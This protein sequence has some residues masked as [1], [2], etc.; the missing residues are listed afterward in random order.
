M[1]T[2]FPTTRWSCV[3]ALHD[4]DDVVRWR[5]LNELLEMYRPALLHYA[6]RVRS[7]TPEHGEDL[8]QGFIVDRVLRG[9]LLIKARAERGRMRSFLLRSFLSYIS[10]QKSKERSLRRQPSGGPPLS[11]DDI[12][13][14]AAL[15]SAQCIALDDAWARQTLS[16]ALAAF[17][18]ECIT[19][20][21]MDW[22]DVFESRVVAPMLDSG[23]AANYDALAERHGFAKPQD[24]ANALVS[25]KRAFGRT[26]RRIVADS[27]PDASHIDEE[28]LAMKEALL[29]NRSMPL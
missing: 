12:P 5:A 25:A 26:L 10:S 15:I 6:V 14:N 19:D 21:R 17:Q 18:T 4:E 11:L 3:L 2:G 28:L 29:K 1:S 13:E 7:Y 22:W 24:A 16:L 20:G 8:V 27:V 9:E 23:A